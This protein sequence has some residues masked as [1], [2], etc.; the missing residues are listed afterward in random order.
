MELDGPN[1]RL[2]VFA[3]QGIDAYYGSPWQILAPW[4]VLSSQRFYASRRLG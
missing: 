4:I 1:A 3:E 2:L